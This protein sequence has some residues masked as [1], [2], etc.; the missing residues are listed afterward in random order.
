MQAAL[1]TPAQRIALIAMC[2][3]MLTHNGT[4]ARPRS[5]SE[6]A[7]RL[8]LSP[9]Y[10]RNVI[11]DVRYRLSEAGVPGLVSADGAATGRIDLRLALAR[12]AIEWG[13]VTEADLADLPRRLGAVR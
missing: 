1:L 2:E 4:H 13:A 11:K 10:A 6:L 8:S 9:D 3:P 12:W 5:T 7:D